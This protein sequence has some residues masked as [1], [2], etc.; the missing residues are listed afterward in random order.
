MPISCGQICFN[1]ASLPNRPLEEALEVG[2]GLGFEAV[3]LLA[4]AGYRHRMGWL[5]GFDWPRMSRTDREGLK[6][7]VRPFARVAIHAPFIDVRP[8]SPNPAIREVSRREVAAAV[9][10]A[11]ELGAD[12]VTTHASAP[13]SF[14]YADVEEELVAYYQWLGRLAE[15]AAV[16]VGIETGWP[17]ARTLVELVKAIDS[18]AVGVTVDVGH[19]LPQFSAGLRKR[20]D[21]AE[22]YN[23]MVVE[24][25][26]QSAQWLVHVHVHDVRPGEWRDHCAVGRGIL[27]W[28]R[29]TEELERA[30]YRGLLSFEL[31]EA[32]DA[33]ALARSKELLSSLCCRA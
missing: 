9:E 3:E 33:A 11:G 6:R 8:L 14:G 18:P 21:A 29:I 5:A 19:L 27:D 1:T 12:V 24:H 7:L 26:R 17:D 15:T 22:K 25:I 28:P 31:E 2:R 16:K 13:P 4:F 10:A 23:E 30:G 32:D 20:P